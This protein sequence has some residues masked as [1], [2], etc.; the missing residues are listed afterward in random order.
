MLE[1]LVVR[2]SDGQVLCELPGAV[3]SGSVTV[4]LG[5]AEDFAVDVPITDRLSPF[6]YGA[7]QVGANLLVGND[8]RTNIP[9]IA[10]VIMNR[11]YG[12]GAA[13]KIGAT[14]VENWLSR[15]SVPV[16]TVRKELTDMVQYLGLHHLETSFHGE[17]HTTSTKFWVERT[18]E[19]NQKSLSAL[20]DL[21]K[22]EPVEFCIRYSWDV[23]GRL[24]PQGII[25]EHIG[26]NS[27]FVFG[28]ATEW[29]VHEDFSEGKGAVVALAYGNKEVVTTSTTTNAEGVEE[30]TEETSQEYISH[31][32]KNNIMLDEGFPPTEYAFKPTD[33]PT[34]V[35]TLARAAQ[36]TL[37]RL[38]R[39]ATTHSVKTLLEDVLVGVDI[40]P[41]DYCQVDLDNP[42]LPGIAES[43]ELRMI[44]Y[45]LEVASN[46]ITYLTPIL[47]EESPIAP[48]G[49][50]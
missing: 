49:G 9:L 12:S 4:G 23:N 46:E 31:T 28:S 48:D 5:W 1:W 18:F 15:V 30:T 38:A 25:A 26:R 24:V 6:W 11:E 37:A 8:S 13:I 36:S 2:P 7:T 33:G 41:G 14:S 27:E 40:Q 29:T 20:H 16:G 50:N 45:T 22:N 35:A 44:G 21:M 43:Y 10:G 34:D 42:D 3:A 19:E 17:I 39:G 47:L 32:E